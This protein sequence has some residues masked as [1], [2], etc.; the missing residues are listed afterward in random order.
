MNK[1]FAVKYNNQPSYAL[2]PLLAALLL[3]LPAMA[4]QAAGPI[5]PD[6]GTI[7]QQIQPALP[8][9]PSPTGTGLTIEPGNGGKL[10]PSAPFLVKTLQI[11]GNAAF[12][13]A[14]LHGLVAD[15]EGQTLTLSNLGDTVARITEYYR[16]HGHP[17]ARAVIPAQGIVNG[18]VRIEII[19]ARYGQIKLDNRSL[20]RDPLLQDTLS[21]VQSGQA[22]TQAELDRSLLLLSD[23]PGVNVNA[24]LTP[25]ETVGTSNLLVNTNA[26]P[27][28]SG[29]G[30]LD[31][32]GNRYTGRARVGGTL[33]VINPL[34]RGDVLTVNALSSGDG[35]NYGR[36]GYE[37]LANGNGTRVGASYSALRYNLGEPLA[38]LNAHGTAQVGSLWA[39][40]PI[41]RKQDVNLYGQ[42]QYDRL[43]LRDRIDVSATQTDRHLG[44]LTV[45]LS[46]DLR[47]TL[48]SGGMNIWSVGWTSGQVDFDNAAAQAA[49]EATAKTQGGFSKWNANFARLQGLSPKSA[50]YVAFA[51][52]WANGNL[53]SSA[54]MSVGGPYSVRAY[55]TGAISADTGY[56]STVEFRYDLGAAWAGQWKAVAFIDSARV[57]VNKNTWVAGDNS[58][59]LS[60]AGV[61]L[62]WAGPNQWNARAYL[63][64]RIGSAPALVA[65]TAS[66]R[67][68]IEIS[69]VY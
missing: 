50:L 31:N 63:A 2:K 55:D 7:L 25:G 46:G 49:D 29:H 8:T 51:G 58:A 28:V 69:K 17:L 21:P 37:S 24:T 53:D 68:W 5:A 10:P 36:L 40:Q 22:I 42:V 13:T 11:S 52:Q 48:L 56:L 39:K 64:K 30:V 45:S 33:N 9:T 43:Q 35:L 23:I 60:G 59:T 15:A 32:Y 20:V 61:G 19:E 34:H 57:T 38:A 54:K 47:D 65:S 3:A 27:T 67:A 44:N 18:V 41:V 1:R 62:N 66:I 14:T 26:G 4:A 6:A 16:R 12:D